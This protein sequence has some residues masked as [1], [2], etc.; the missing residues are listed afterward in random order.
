V[1]DP[2]ADYE[3]RFRRAGLPLLIE[4]RTAATDIW[5]RALPLL[6]VVFWV[7][8]LGA[9]DL[10]WS[11]WQNALAL[12]GGVVIL[13]GAWAASN[14]ARR[15]KAFALPRDVGFWELTGFVVIPALLPLILN[16]QPRS[17][18]VTALGNLCLLGL[19]YLAIGYGLL[20]IVA[21]A[22]RRLFS[23]LTASINLIARAIPLLMIFS[24]VLFLT[25][26]VWQVFADMDNGT[27]VA[28]TL[29]FAAVGTL[30]LAV[31]V[32][33]EVTALEAQVAAGPPLSGRQRI[34]VGL[35]LF[36]S[37]A[38]QVLFIAVAVGA[39]FVAFGMLVLDD[40]VI[41]EWTGHA[42]NYLGTLD[43]SGVRLAITEQQL[44][45][46]GAIAALSGLYYAVA[47]LTDSTYREEFLTEVMDE[48]TTTFHDRAGYLQL[49]GGGVTR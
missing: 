24:V 4:G 12:L 33:R 46:A 14:L 1:S 44:R 11:W 9:L 6:G 49:V 28:T 2:R 17:A 31:R 27:L 48:M 45:V 47:V 29:L 32:P 21:W 35:I 38:L 20:S 8:M 15:R 42:P 40:H 30:F 10:A 25:T 41:R 34:N 16:V 7:E 36:V 18:L 22:G 26:E 23:Q 3:S 43:V 5:T 13:A 37:Q 39:F 19:L